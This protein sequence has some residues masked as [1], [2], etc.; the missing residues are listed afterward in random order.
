MKK[1][2]TLLLLVFCIV[3]VF[4][5]TESKHT[6]NGKTSI[7]HED[8][9]LPYKNDYGTMKDRR[10]GKTYKT[11]SIG[12]QVWMAENLVYKA[13]NGCWA[14][15]KNQ[16]NV[17]KYGY[18]YNWET[19]KNVCP[20]GWHLPSKQEYETMLDNFGG[21]EDLNN[22]NYTA[23]IP[24]GTSSFSALFGGWRNHGNGNFSL[25]GDYG[26]FFSS[27][28]YDPNYA[29]ALVIYRGNEEARIGGFYKR[30]GCS[31]RCVQDN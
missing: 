3:S 19:A 8:G 13:N 30:L 24:G 17:A 31:V 21:S 28:Q 12:S 27:S 26:F 25:I 1:L 22:E 29:W 20:S 5:Q 14:Y 10:D 15:D 7:I 11:V 16:S 4:A 18:L 2:S 23:L 9:T 6:K